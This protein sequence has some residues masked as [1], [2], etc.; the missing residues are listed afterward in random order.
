LLASENFRSPKNLASLPKKRK[1]LSLK[2]EDFLINQFN[3]KIKFQGKT[4]VDFFPDNNKEKVQK[5]P[6]SNKNLPETKN[7]SNFFFFYEK[8]MKQN[9]R[10]EQIETEEAQGEVNTNEINNETQKT[11]SIANSQKNIM[12]KK[13]QKKN[14]YC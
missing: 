2:N 9:L 13:K 3:S 11:F 4:A 8:N 7:Q 10:T 14:H 1:E 12:K 6:E 5:E